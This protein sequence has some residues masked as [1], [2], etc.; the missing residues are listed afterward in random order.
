VQEV[1]HHQVQ[2]MMEVVGQIQ[3]LVQSLLQV[4]EVE[5]D[6][7]KLVILEVQA[8]AEAVDQQLEKQVVQVIHHQLVHHKAIMEEQ[9]EVH[10]Q[11]NRLVE[12]VEQQ[13]SEEMLVIQ[14]QVQEVQEQ[15]LQ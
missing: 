6:T 3:F 4:A 8:V 7:F 1:Q 14:Y 12:V 10:H 11:I 15:Q 5:E 2:V 9:V 13:Q